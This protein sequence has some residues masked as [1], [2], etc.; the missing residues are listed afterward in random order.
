MSFKRSVERDRK[1][2]FTHQDIQNKSEFKSQFNFTW[3][4]FN[5]KSLIML[6]IIFLFTQ[7]F[8]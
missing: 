8:E 6:A 7:F 3:I 1:I 4:P 5:Y 2:E